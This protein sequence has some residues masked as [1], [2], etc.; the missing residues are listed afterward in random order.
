M[1]WLVCQM[2]NYYFGLIKVFSYFDHTL[3]LSFDIRFNFRSI[4]LFYCLAGKPYVTSLH[5]VIYFLSTLVFFVIGV[6]THGQEQNGIEELMTTVVLVQSLVNHGD[7]F[8][9]NWISVKGAYPQVSIKAWAELFLEM[10]LFQL[11]RHSWPE[12]KINNQ[13]Q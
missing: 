12:A 13:I 2:Q 1:H 8:V 3:L 4:F 9:E 10:N 11:T 7:S 5:R 6:C